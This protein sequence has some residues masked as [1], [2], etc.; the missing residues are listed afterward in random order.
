MD[1]SHNENNSRSAVIIN[2]LG[3]PGFILLATFSGFALGFAIF[4]YIGA[5]REAQ[6]A[7]ARAEQQTRQLQINERETRLLEYYVMELDGKL[8]RQ[9]IID[10]ADSWS[11]KKRVRKE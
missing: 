9:G 5:I 7:S 6:N 8:M 2:N 4:S 11:A 10:P 1:G 3:K